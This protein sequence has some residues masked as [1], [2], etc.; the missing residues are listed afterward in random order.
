MVQIAPS[1]LA[2]DFSR[3]GE[4]VATVAGAGADFIHIDVMDGHFVPNITMGPLVVSAVKRVTTVPLDVHLMIT[5]PDQYL[6]AFAQAGAATISV[7]VEATVHLHRTLS[8]IRQLGAR[9]GV[10]IN[11][12]TPLDAI[13][14][15]F[16]LLDQVIVMS[17]N[18]G[19]GGQ[20]FIPRS[21][22]R[23]AD[24]RARL[25]G[26]PV[27]IEVDGGVDETNA[28][29]LIRAGASI[30]VAGNS[31]FGAPDPAAAT[32]ALRRAATS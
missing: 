19:F 4:Q 20:S 10:A 5:N 2:A 27:D 1:I 14:E 32:R 28:A 16:D 9:A 17:V 6:E 21:I 22:E 18:P 15:V 24:L 7:H 29:T 30:L 12:A 23:I 31:V 3:L 26:R 13:G 11:P 25:G 8:R